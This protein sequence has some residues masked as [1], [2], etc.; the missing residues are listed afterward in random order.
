MRQKFD[1]S[2]AE[3]PAAIVEHHEALIAIRVAGEAYAV[4]TAQIT[5]LAK[6][7]RI[8]PVPSLVPGLLGITALRGA[9][10]PAYDVAALL[11]LSAAGGEHTWIMFADGDMPVGLVFDQFEGQVEIDRACLYESDSSS[12]SEL[13]GQIA[14][15]GGDSR[16]VINVPGLVKEIRKN[17]GFIEPAKE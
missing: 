2:F 15:V 13:L 4:R 3:Q 5:G 11:G 17:A 6:L 1:Q 16:A 8:M 14:R 12:S 10:F 9:L 7:K